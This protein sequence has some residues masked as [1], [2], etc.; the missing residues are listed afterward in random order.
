MRRTFRFGCCALAAGIALAARAAAA[1]EFGSFSYPPQA[2]HPFGAATVSSVVNIPKS[3]P[4]VHGFFVN[5]ILPRDY[6]ANAKVRIVV[7][8]QN[9]VPG[10]GCDIVFEPQ[11]FARWRPG[12]APLPFST[13]LSAADGSRLVSFPNKNVVTKVFT[14]VRDPALPGQRP[15]DGLRAALGRPGGDPDDTCGGTV[16]VPGIEILYPRTP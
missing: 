14:V 4:G 12:A 3:D 5:F 16:Q 8:M 7:H 13:G 11:S 1:E 15:G 10:R 9:A 2:V 6:R